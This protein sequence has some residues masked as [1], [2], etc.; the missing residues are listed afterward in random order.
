MDDSPATVAAEI[1]KLYLIPLY[2]VIVPLRPQ[3]SGLHN[4]IIQWGAGQTLGSRD[5]R[6]RKIMKIILQLT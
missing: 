3:E 5:E 6:L 4:Q 2:D 1:G